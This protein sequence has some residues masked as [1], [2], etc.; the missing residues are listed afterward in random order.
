TPGGDPN[1][2]VV[3]PDTLTLDGGTVNFSSGLLSF[4]SSQGS[5][6]AGPGGGTVNL[7]LNPAHSASAQIT[8]PAGG[9][10]TISAG[11]LVHGSAGTIG[12][13]GNTAV[14]VATGATVSGDSAGAGLT[15]VGAGV[16][17]VGPGLTNDG[18]IQAVSGGTIS[19][20]ATTWINAG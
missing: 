1:V 20:N 19:I 11:I 16:T 6:V 3:I 8:G 17:G 4:N 10:L 15:F 14:V 7:N 2:V 13:S 5:L 18:T 9:T 12:N